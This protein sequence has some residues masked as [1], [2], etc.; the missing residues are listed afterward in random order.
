MKHKLCK[1]FVEHLI[2]QR[3]RNAIL[4]VLG[5]IFAA[6]VAYQV[7]GGRVIAFAYLAFF[8]ALP[9]VF[10]AYKKHKKS[11]EASKY[12]W[13]EVNNANIVY[14]T[15]LGEEVIY[16]SQIK[17]IE[18][19]PSQWPTLKLTLSSGGGLTLQGFEN[20]EGIA[21]EISKNIKT[22]DMQV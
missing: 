12:V 3:K 7:F 11:I 10:D 13:V 18:L 1:D 22:C 6:Y 19:M 8:I 14:G 17:K 21:T 16:L 9:I 2:S 15:Q 5:S 4:I 20:M